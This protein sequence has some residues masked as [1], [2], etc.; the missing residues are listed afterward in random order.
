MARERG[1]L[2]WA[3]KNFCLPQGLV[4]L[5]WIWGHIF[6][7]P[8]PLVPSSLVVRRTRCQEQHAQGSSVTLLP[9][10]NCI[11]KLLNPVL[12]RNPFSS[13]GHL[14]EEKGKKFVFFSRSKYGIDI[15]EV[16]ADTDGITLIEEKSWDMD[17][18]KRERKHSESLMCTW[19]WTP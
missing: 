18:E 6:N 3:M 17:M 11:Y 5:D 7:T 2:W 14:I 8:H 19:P 16:D 13:R 1:T 10:P 12:L 4:F 9:K 15:K